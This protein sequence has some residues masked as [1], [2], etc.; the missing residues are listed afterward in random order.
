MCYITYNNNITHCV[1]RRGAGSG[2]VMAVD[3]Q[4]Q[5]YSEEYEDFIIE[6]TGQRESIEEFYGVSCYQLV[7]SQFG[8]VYQP[9][10]EV[11]DSQRN[12]LLIM[13]RCFGLLSSEQTLDEAD[14]FRVRRQ[15]NLSLYGQG[16]L[17]GIIDTGA[18]V[19]K[20]NYYLSCEKRSMG[21]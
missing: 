16:V 10:R 20:K 2:G 1:L 21:D 17:L 15:P 11:V 14:I 12:T 9:S 6:Y 5:I 7:D 18:G 8:V 3:C 13:P 19:R 4:E